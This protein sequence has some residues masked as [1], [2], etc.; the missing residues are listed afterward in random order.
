MGIKAPGVP[1]N[2]VLFGFAI[3]SITLLL[4]NTHLENVTL[5]LKAI[6]NSQYVPAK[7]GRSSRHKL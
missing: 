1:T 4:L 6:I 5:I 7:H 3:K 2:A